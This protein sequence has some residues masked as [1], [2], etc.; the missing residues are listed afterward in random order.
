M[1]HFKKMMALALAM[2]MVLA[3]SL[4]VFAQTQAYSGTDGDGATITVNN[5]ARGETYKIYKLF[6]ATVSENGDIAYQSTAA[7]PAGLASCF[8]KD[9]NNNISPAPSICVY[10]TEDPTKVVGT[11]S[12][13]LSIIQLPAYPINHNTA[14][15]IFHT[16]PP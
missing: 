13:R 7:I 14:H 16:G 10:D 4:P 5:P 15:S 12:L 6:D 3:M 11:L 8:T 1:K 2:V 9:A